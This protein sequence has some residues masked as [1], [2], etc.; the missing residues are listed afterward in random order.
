[1]KRQ[2]FSLVEILVVTTIAISI[3]LVVSNLSN[4]ISLLN[5]LVG[6][7]LQSKSD[8][9]QTLQ[10]VTTDIRSATLSAN[11]AYPVS[12]ATTSTFTFYTDSDGDGA[13]ERVRY[14]LSS[15]SIY[16]GM[17]QPTGT[18]ASYPTATEVLTDMID[19]VIIPTSTT[20]FK[21]YDASYTG[22]QPAMTSTA[23]VTGIRLVGMSFYSDVR[24]KQAPG[25][26]FFSILVDI[27]NLRNN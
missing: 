25:P 6:Q 5:G 23:D 15:S 1:M 3:V 2:G 20:L 21:Y 24:P 4:N 26:Q 14:F 12:T 27:R 10:I 19:N 17:I 9:S 7:E 11:G 16:R 18:P 8:T 22:T 13:V